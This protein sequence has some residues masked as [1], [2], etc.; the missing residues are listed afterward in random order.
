MY[1]LP[2]I[3]VLDFCDWLKHKIEKEKSQDFILNFSNKNENSQSSLEMYAKQYL[4]EQNSGCCVQTI[5]RQFLVSKE[6]EQIVKHCNYSHCNHGDL[7][8]CYEC[9]GCG[10]EIEHALHH[11]IKEQCIG[12]V[13]HSQ[14]FSANDLANY[15]RNISNYDNVYITFIAEPPWERICVS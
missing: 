4:Q 9:F 12:I 10:C 13:H 1:S 6:L 5:I 7:C 3:V 8:T 15:I 14:S 2:D 11:F